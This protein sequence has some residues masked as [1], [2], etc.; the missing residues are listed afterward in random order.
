MPPSSR[1]VKEVRITQKQSLDRINDHIL[2]ARLPAKRRKSK[3]TV[4]IDIVSRQMGNA[5]L[6]T[7]AAAYTVG[8]L[9][10]LEVLGF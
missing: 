2:T 4:F 3:T 1:V 10:T 6:A 5:S 8:S 7:P 9:H